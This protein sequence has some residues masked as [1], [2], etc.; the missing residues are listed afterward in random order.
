[1]TIYNCCNFKTLISRTFNYLILK[2]NKT[3]NVRNI[4]FCKNLQSDYSLLVYVKGIKMIS[5]STVWIYNKT[6]LIFT[7]ITNVSNLKH[8][9]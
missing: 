4:L 1:M 3:S 6:R 9:F 7:L 2:L 8:S 5:L